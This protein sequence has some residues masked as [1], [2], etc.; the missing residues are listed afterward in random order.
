MNV[1]NETKIEIT[2]L[3]LMEILHYSTSNITSDKR[4]VSEFVLE[5]KNRGYMDNKTLGNILGQINPELRKPE[6]I[7]V[8]TRMVPYWWPEEMGSNGL[9][10]RDLR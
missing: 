9:M 10:W 6:K 3:E 8:A 2:L 7:I 5:L 4:I 1:S